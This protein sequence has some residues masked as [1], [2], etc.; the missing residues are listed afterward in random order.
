[1][2]F[3]IMTGERRTLHRRMRAAAARMR[4]PS[5]FTLIEMLVVML[6][7]ACLLN[8]VAPNYF[9]KAK[10]A[11]EVVLKQNLRTMRD[12]IDHFHADVGRY[13]L[14]LDELIA[15]R[16]LREAPLD[17]VTGRADSWTFTSR[18]GAAGIQD[19]H[20]GAEGKGADGT[21]FHTW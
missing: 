5:G 18:Q 20:S 14:S 4:L 10:R 1:M 13:P 11:D 16:Y 7:A 8:L 2:E 17:P 21:P 19:V 12:A 9:S 15:R 3:L 6:I